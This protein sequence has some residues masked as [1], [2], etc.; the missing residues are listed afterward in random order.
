MD[1]NFI[2]ASLKSSRGSLRA[3]ST[4]DDNTLCASYDE[5]NVDVIRQTKRAKRPTHSSTSCAQSPGVEQQL[6]ALIGLLTRKLAKDIGDEED[7]DDK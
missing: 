2:G 3:R 7:K 6:S 5:E 1:R 4:T